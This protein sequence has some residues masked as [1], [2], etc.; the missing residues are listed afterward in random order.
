[1]RLTES[2][3]R[4]IVRGALITEGAKGKI[5]SLIDA[6]VEI[7]E[8]SVD[9]SRTVVEI[10]PGSESA[11]FRFKHMGAQD[12]GRGPKGGVQIVK[13]SSQGYGECSGAWVVVG[14]EVSSGWGPLLYDIAIEWAT[15]NGGGLTSDR[16]EVSEDALRVWFRYSAQRGD[17][18]KAQLD[19]SD[20]DIKNYR[21]PGIKDKLK[22]LTRITPKDKS[23]DCD[24]ESSFMHQSDQ[25]EEDE[26]PDW[27]NS[28]LSRVYRKAPVAMGRLKELGLLITA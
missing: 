15:Q 12:S 27:Y 10:R 4:R 22:N 1:V 23:D 8:K 25:W 21:Q 3:L 18:Q 28:P 17:V 16:Q 9:G 20:S 13:A 19:L 26:V 7:N 2:Q 5:D 6:L 14:S 24:Q 11:V